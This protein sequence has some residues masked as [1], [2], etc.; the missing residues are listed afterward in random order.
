M[1]L[2][3]ARANLAKVQPRAM[4]KECFVRAF[5]TRANTHW[6]R[7]H[8]FDC[9]W[10]FQR[11]YRY[12]FKQTHPVLYLAADHLVASSEVGPRTRLELLVPH[13][14][15]AVD[16]YVYVTVKVTANLLDLTDA[17]TR[18]LLG[19][20]MLKELLVPTKKWDD[21]MDKGTWSAT[22]HLGKLALE[23][24]RFDG[25]LYPAQPPDELLELPGKQNV[26]LFMDP[27]VATMSRPLHASVKL[28]VVDPA[29]L[30]KRL[31]LKL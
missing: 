2:R 31:G 3:R 6:G 1:D 15:A 9:T 8:F 16:P 4:H 21:D 18:S 30:L 19:G 11:G 28:E 14:Q 10:S 12:N 17:H 27:S 23:G 7:D 5:D 20:V 22:H 25:I 13:L 29:G 26:A 24:D